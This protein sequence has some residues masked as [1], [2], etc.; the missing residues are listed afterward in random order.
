M[1]NEANAVQAVTLPLRIIVIEASLNPKSRSTALAQQL[2]ARMVEFG[3]PAKLIDLREYNLPIC[4]GTEASMAHPMVEEL[5]KEFR[6]ATHIIFGVPIYNYHVNAAV[7]NMVELVFAWGSWAGG[8]RSDAEGKIVGFICSAGGKS[9]YMSVIPF[10]NSLMLDCRIWICPRFVYAT[11]EDM[12][13]PD[14][15]QRIDRLIDDMLG[16]GPVA[17]HPWRKALAAKQP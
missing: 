1:S 16:M 15:A 17:E 3:L 13:T 5:R 11:K 12:G 4:D 6:T 14:L 9:S 8:K 2:Y 7:K 10:A